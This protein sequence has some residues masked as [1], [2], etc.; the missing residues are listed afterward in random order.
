MTPS[1]SYDS[2]LTRALDRA[3]NLLCVGIDP[4]LERLP[5]ELAAVGE[6]ALGACIALKLN[7]G[8]GTSMG[9][10]AAK[11][12]AQALRIPMIGISS[13]DLLAFT[14]PHADRIVV[15]RD[16]HIEQIGAPL[17]LYDRPANVFVA[18]F[19]GNPA[20]NLMDGTLS[21][22]VFEGRNVR[23]AGL[24]GP[25]GPVTL[26]FRANLAMAA[27]P[28]SRLEMPREDHANVMARM[29]KAHA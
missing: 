8:L 12:I 5:G 17:E 22:G 15:M 13:L 25:D 20:M 3:G 18:G 21:G 11:S 19:I 4:V 23:I 6:A 16:G 2:I 27:G 7:G 14:E 10:A 28:H 26:G 9:L 1:T 24:E 29:R